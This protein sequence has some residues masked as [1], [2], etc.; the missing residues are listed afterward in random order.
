M[1]N[2][3]D[4]VPRTDISTVLMEA[5]GQ[6]KQYIAQNLAPIY[7][8][9]TEVGRY[10]RFR[11]QAMELLRAA[12]NPTQS[13]GTTTFNSSTKRGAT[14][15]YNELTRKFEWDSYQT[16]E[17]GAE[18]RVDDVVA[19]RMTNFFDAEMVTAEALMH[20][21]MLDFEMEVCAKLNTTTSTDSSE[22]LVSTNSGVA[23]NE[24]TAADGTMNAPKDINA[25]IERLTLLGTNPDECDIVLS[26]TIF[27]LVRRS[28]KFQTYVFGTLNTSQGGSMITEQMIAQAFGLRSCIV[29]KKSVDVAIKGL[30]PSLVNVWGNTNV[31]VGKFGEG[32]FM[33]GGLL[34]T[35]TWGADSAGGLFTSESYR[36][37]KRRGTMLRVRSNRVL[38]MIDPTCGQLLATQ[39]S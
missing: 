20:E 27:N 6:K 5:V 38:K 33:N 2:T 22:G 26:L 23:W 8:S 39:Y 4:S 34:R 28:T 32:D 30:T 29:A 35:I 3:S 31:L 17:Y 12:R 24:T 36:D 11:K 37:E 9:A 19:K 7:D 15:T 21:L 18:E 14:G 16:E 1:Y 25:L 10:P 13:G